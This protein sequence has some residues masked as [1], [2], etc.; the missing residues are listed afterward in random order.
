M[1]RAFR[2]LPVGEGSL[3]QMFVPLGIA[4]G[5]ALFFREHFLPHELLGAFLILVGSA[6]PAWKS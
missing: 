1:T 5:G 6:L 3:L 2:D 4:V